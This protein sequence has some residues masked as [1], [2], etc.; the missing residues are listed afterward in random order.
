MAF[1][2][3]ADPLNFAYL[4]DD[5][6]PCDFCGS[7]EHRLDG[8]H[9]YGVGKIAAACFSCVERGAPIER[10]ISTNNVNLT[11]ANNALGTAAADPITNQII[12]CTP[13]LPTWQ[14]T[15]WPF[16]DGDFATFLKIASKTDFSDQSHFADTILPDDIAEPDPE[17]QWDM[18]PDHPVTNLK[19]G[20]YDISIYLFRRADRLVTILDAN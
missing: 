11:Q 4:R 3:F 15:D 10:D 8:D 7:T 14:D 2:Y 19:E 1:R 18:L 20:Q 12:Y 5:A 6:T 9:F 17:W 13:S 16:V